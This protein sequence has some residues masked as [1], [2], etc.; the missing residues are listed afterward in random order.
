MH[1]HV[2]DEYGNVLI[3]VAGGKNE[4]GATLDTT[5]IFNVTSNEWKSGKMADVSVKM[6]INQKDFQQVQNC[7]SK[8]RK[9]PC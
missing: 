2:L 9:Q 8:L 3:M 1:L 4:K 7:P 5:E 6:V